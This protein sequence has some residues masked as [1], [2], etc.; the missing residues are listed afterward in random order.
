MTLRRRPPT[1]GAYRDIVITPAFFVALVIV[2]RPVRTPPRPELDV[3]CSSPH[4]IAYVP[5]HSDR[6]HSAGGCLFLSF[7]LRASPSSS[8]S[9]RQTEMRFPALSF[10]SF[11]GIHSTLCASRPLAMSSSEA[12][13]P[14]GGPVGTRFARRECSSSEPSPAMRRLVSDRPARASI[15]RHRP[16][17]S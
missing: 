10:G 13:P 4:G 5:G 8:H 17:V 1:C 15:S 11:Y 6:C 2:L 9:P 3:A 16:P 12:T 14:V 7:A